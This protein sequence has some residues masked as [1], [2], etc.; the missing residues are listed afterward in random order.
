MEQRTKWVNIVCTKRHTYLWESNDD[1]EETINALLENREI[2]PFWYCPRCDKKYPKSI[3]NRN[4]T[5]DTG[6]R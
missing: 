4:L 1:R 3:F 6:P 2:N 5:S